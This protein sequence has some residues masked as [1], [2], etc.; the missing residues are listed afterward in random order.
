MIDIGN[1]VLN[2][3][4]Y[5]NLYGYY[6]TPTFA[7]GLYYA[8]VRIFANPLVTR[9]PHEL[10]IIAAPNRVYIAKVVSRYL[11]FFTHKKGAYWFSNPV[12]D[13][14]NKFH[15]YI[16]GIN[17]P[18]TNLE[19][20][21]SKVNDLITNRE[22]I[23]QVKSHNPFLIRKMSFGKNFA[24]VID[25]SAPAGQNAQ[26]IRT[27]EPQPFRLRLLVRFGIYIK[28]KQEIESEDGS[29]NGNSNSRLV[30]LTTQTILQQV[31]TVQ[32][33]SNFSA[34]YASKILK[35]LSGLEKNWLNYLSGA[36][37]WK[38]ILVLA[39]AAV[40]VVMVFVFSGSMGGGGDPLAALGPKPTG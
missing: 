9:N 25:P 7:L 27:K 2:I 39:I 23:K 38:I 26:L 35:T 20:S 13:G 3:L 15:V 30:Q 16:D 21:E 17:Q 31:N 36:F 8:I 22:Y 29:S 33:N 24:L 1:V 18:I 34:S 12:T 5:L 6:V 32:E 11:P 4:V 19:R 40:A 14:F 10:V 37:D 28:V